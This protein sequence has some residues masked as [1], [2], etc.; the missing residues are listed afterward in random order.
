MSSSVKGN[1]TNTIGNPVSACVVWETFNTSTKPNVGDVVKNVVYKSGTIV[2]E[3]T[4]KAG[5]ALIAVK[6]AS[7]AI[8]WSWHIWVT[9]YNPSTDYDIYRGFEGLKVMDRNLGALS[10]EKG[11]KSVGMVYQ[12]GRKDPFMGNANG[13]TFAATLEPQTITTSSSIG[14]DSYAIKNPNHFIIASSQGGDW[15][16]TP[17]SEAWMSSKTELDPC[18]KGWKVP[19][20]G[21]NGLWK[22]YAIPNSSARE[23]DLTNKGMLFGTDYALSPVWM[24]AQGYLSDSNT[25]HTGW[26]Q[27][28]SEGRYWSS[29]ILGSKHSEFFQFKPDQVVISH[30]SS[31]WNTHCS[32]ATGMPIRCV[33]DK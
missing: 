5:N 16:Y 6:D 31:E 17:F 9:D 12:W 25:Y 33:E 8:L 11:D 14:T 1:S 24:P 4:N 28:G 15:R 2:F 13:Y 30:K 29:T 27:V 10:S 20:G 18:P 7:N 23:F 32:R 3:T 21:E 19:E 22:K 26:W